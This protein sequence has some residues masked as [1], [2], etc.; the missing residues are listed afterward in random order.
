MANLPAL[1]QGLEV[2]ELG[3]QDFQP[4]LVQQPPLHSILYT[5]KVEISYGLVQGCS[6]DEVR[7]DEGRQAFALC[8]AA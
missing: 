7:T 4:C 6:V 5:E 1:S 3:T 8:A 2:A